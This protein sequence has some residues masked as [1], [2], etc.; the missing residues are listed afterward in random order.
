MSIYKYIHMHMRTSPVRIAQQSPPHPAR[1]S[2]D[3]Y[4]HAHAQE[5]AIYDVPDLDGKTCHA[6]YVCTIMYT[7]TYMYIYIQHVLDAI[8]HENY[9]CVYIRTKM[10]VYTYIYQHTWIFTYI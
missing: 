4:I 8:Y 10:Y 6:W 5:V 3:S 2:T 9:L 1:P 7:H